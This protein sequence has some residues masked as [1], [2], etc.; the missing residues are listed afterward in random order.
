MGLKNRS[1]QTLTLPEGYIRIRYVYYGFQFCSRE[2]GHLYKQPILMGVV[3]HH[4][5]LMF[6][7]RYYI[8]YNIYVRRE[9]RYP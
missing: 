1:Y 4:I 5:L 2:N 6:L 8:M 9:G 7:R 3:L